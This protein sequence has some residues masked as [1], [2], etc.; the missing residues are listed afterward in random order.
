MIKS[1]VS[2]CPLPNKIEW[3]K[4]SDGQNFDF[5]DISKREYYGSSLNVTSPKLQI[6]KTT[7]DDQLYYRLF[8]RN[9]IG[10][11]ISDSLHLNV[12]GGI[13]LRFSDHLLN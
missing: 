9:A 6:P 4:S 5:I 10:E 3:Q 7:F 13:Q 12:A 11:E 8:V 2:S 1:T